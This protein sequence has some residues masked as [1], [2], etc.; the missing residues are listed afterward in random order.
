MVVVFVGGVFRAERV[1]V[2][3]ELVDLAIDAVCAQ[4]DL[5]RVRNHGLLLPVVEL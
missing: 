1:H 5:L 2:G 3:A 4:V